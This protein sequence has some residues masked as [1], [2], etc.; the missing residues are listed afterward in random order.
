MFNWGFGDV[1]DSAQKHDSVTE[2]SAL[3]RSLGEAYIQYVT[4]IKKIMLYS[5]TKL[6]K[7]TSAKKPLNLNK[8]NLRK[9]RGAIT[10][11]DD[12]WLGT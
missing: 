8:T 1:K 7:T 10:R 4:M 11:F 2:D 6:S 9:R 3:S 5:S 12:K